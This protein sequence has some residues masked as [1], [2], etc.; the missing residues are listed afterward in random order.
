MRVKS[1]TDLPKEMQNES[2]RVYYDILRNRKAQLAVKRAFDIVAALILLILLSPVMLVIAVLIKIG[3]KGSV[4]FRQTRVTTYGR[5]FR[6]FKFRTMVADAEALGTQVTTLGDARITKTG[7]FLR[8]TRLDEIPQLLNIIAGSMTL[9]GTRPEVPKYVKHYTDEMMATLL[10]PAGVTSSASIL[11][12][13]EDKL[14]ATAE[15]ADE[16]YV[17]EIMPHKLKHNLDY[18]KCFSLSGDFR[19]LLETIRAVGRVGS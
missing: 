11:Y 14:L 17:N 1:F 13:D 19:V 10:L 2:V 16:V 4:F 18:I 8:R 9:V 3:S 7:K 6:I 12:K 15:N 5:E